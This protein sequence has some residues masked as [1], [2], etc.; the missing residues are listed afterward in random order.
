MDFIPNQTV[1]IVFLSKTIYEI[2]FMLI[3][4]LGKVRGHACI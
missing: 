3:H 1:D 2:V 4:T